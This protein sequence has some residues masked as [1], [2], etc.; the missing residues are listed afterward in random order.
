MRLEFKKGYQNKLLLEF[1]R[2][3]K[4]S[5]RELAKFLFKSRRAVRYWIKEKLLLPEDIF[6]KLIK[7]C[8][9]INNY[10]K[11]ILIKKP[12]N[13]GQIKGGKNRYY[14]LKRCNGFRKHL[15]KM[16]RKNKKAS[17]FPIPKQTITF[18]KIKNQKINILALLITL[19][20]TEGYL[21]TNKKSIYFTTKDKILL[22]LFTDIISHLSKRNIY[23][24]E[25]KGIFE[26][27][28]YNPLLVKKLLKYSPTYKTSPKNQTKREYLN[29]PQPT[30]NY[31]FN[32]NLKTKIMCIRLALSTDGCLT[33]GSESK[34]K[35]KRRAKLILACANSSLTKQW[36][37]LF[38]QVGLNF[39]IMKH[40]RTWDNIK[41]IATGN[42]FTI[43]KFKNMGGFIDGV[44]ISKKS[45]YF[46]G[47]TK[48]QL[49]NLICNYSTKNLKNWDDIY[50]LI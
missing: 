19:L 37:I 8:S 21:R 40:K 18:K 12:K 10:N 16:L 34:N 20:M 3:N 2:L 27:S 7:K 39:W 11:F 44:K 14:Q 43:K 41:G 47:Y 38:E 31:L 6:K 32:Q 46:T 24:R 48:N 30:I 50:K 49:L 28:A 45:P 25:R 23:I 26:A 1:M 29:G 36:K 17:L 4:L 15:K 35:F 5:Q 22:N 33:F 13:W 42:I 9:S